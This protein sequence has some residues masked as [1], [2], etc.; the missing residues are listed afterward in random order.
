MPKRASFIRMSVTS[1]EERL[2]SVL[3]TIFCDLRLNRP[4]PVLGNNTPDTGSVPQRPLF[5]QVLATSSGQG[6]VSLKVGTR[7]RFLLTLYG[8]STQYQ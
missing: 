4:S 1:P 2:I 3:L 8:G 6:A 7:V 5:K